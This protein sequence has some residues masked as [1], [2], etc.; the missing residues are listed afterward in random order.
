MKRVEVS[1]AVIQKDNKILVTQRGYGKWKGKW[2]FP[3]GKI[4]PGETKEEALQRE[5]QEELGVEI[6]IGEYLMKTEYDYP[7]FHVTLY[8][9][10]CSLG[11]DE[12]TLTEHTAAKWLCRSALDC[13]D[14]MP[15]NRNLIE[16]LMHC[17]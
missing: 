15:A 16:Y 8:P 1:I 17:I 11:R 5:I 4:E 14:W 13:V 7:D 10:L 2:E 6:S 12:I 3:G 9:F